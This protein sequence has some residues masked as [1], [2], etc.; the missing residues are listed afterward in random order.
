MTSLLSTGTS[1]NGTHHHHNSIAEED[2]TPTESDDD[3]D[4]DR[5]MTKAELQKRAAKS[6]AGLQV[7]PGKLQPARAKA[8]AMKKKK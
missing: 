4:S 8:V 5:P 6:I 7:V 2:P 3:D 1:F